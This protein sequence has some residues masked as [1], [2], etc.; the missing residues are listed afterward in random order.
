[1]TSY[2]T[3]KWSLLGLNK[4]DMQGNSLVVQ[5]LGLRAST[6][7]VTGSIPDSWGTKIPQAS[8][9]ERKGG[10]EGGREKE[11]KTCKT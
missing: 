10:R 7:G 8:E 4:K 6:A 3:T 9:R 2:P 1:M 11:R 5:W